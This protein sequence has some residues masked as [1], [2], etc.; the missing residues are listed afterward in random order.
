M[1]F[2]LVTMAHPDGPGWNQHVAEHV[3]YLQQLVASG[4]LRASGPLK[5]TPQ[6]AGF[7]IFTVADRATVETLVTRDPFSIE[8]LIETLTIV[9]WDPLFGAFAT[10]S[11]GHLGG[12]S[13][14]LPS[15]ERELSNVAIPT[16]RSAR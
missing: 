14:A 11:S 4:A 5:G 15:P 10:D 9:E 2:F 13:D 16:K 6:R 1:K 12:L 3:G 8:K 7:L